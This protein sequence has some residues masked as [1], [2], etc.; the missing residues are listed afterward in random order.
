MHPR[1]DG[2]YTHPIY[3][4]SQ[5][6]RAL[7]SAGIRIASEIATH[8]IVF[9]EY[10]NNYHTPSAE[11]DK[12]TGMYYCFSCESTTDLINLI[13]KKGY[14]YFEARR[15]IG[16]NNYNL[17][18]QVTKM[19]NPPEIEEFD[20]VVVERLHADVWE[21]GREY[22]N[23]RHI[24]DGS[25][26][27]FQLGYSKKQAMVTVPVHSPTGTLWGFVGRSI[28]GKKFKNNRGLNKSLTLFNIHRVWTSERAFV[29]ESSFDAIRLDQLGIPAV[30]TLGAGISNE[31]VDILKRTFDEIVLVPDNDDAGRGMTSK[32]LKAMPYAKILTLEGVKD[33]GDLSDE[34]LTT[35]I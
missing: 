16:D 17:T 3:E 11:V 23:S 9:C 6:E 27:K 7:R 34:D 25:I 19:L 21:E 10:H 35:L 5:V 4:A 31:Q 12:E 8:F 30:A 29:V 28:E 22:F 13:M 26:T 15:L 18:E 32:I 1:H 33:V 24:S 20:A 2:E 14:S